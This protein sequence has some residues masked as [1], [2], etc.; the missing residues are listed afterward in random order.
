MAEHERAGQ[1]LRERLAALEERLR[2]QTD[3]PTD[4]EL[5][6]EVAALRRLPRTFPAPFPRNSSKS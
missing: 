3:E 2:S 6:R 1:V 5:E 4:A